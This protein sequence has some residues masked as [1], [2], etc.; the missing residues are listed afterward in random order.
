M[1]KENIFKN[2][3]DAGRKL[4]DKLLRYKAVHP[5]VLALPRGGVPVGYE[6]AVKLNTTLDTIVARKIGSP[7]NPE[8]GVGAI[9]PGDVIILN[10][11]IIQSLGI[12]NK[13]LDSIIESE[14]NEMDRRMVR[15]RSGEY[16]RYAAAETIIIVDDGLAT[17]VTARAAIESVK[18]TYKPK[19]IIFTAP[20]CAHDTAEHIRKLVD[21]FVCVKEVD[22]LMAIGY[23]YK[24][25]DQTTDEEVIHYLVR[26]K[27]K[28]RLWGIFR[29]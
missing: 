23:W 20:V 26:R 15:Y 16:S 6:V 28:G 24:N 5:L 12:D 25:F 19:K 17:G 11:S 13:D 14:M 3:I 4:A 22:N 21:D 2:R 1:N 18:L 8:F 9:A 10:D 7:H 29:F 27:R